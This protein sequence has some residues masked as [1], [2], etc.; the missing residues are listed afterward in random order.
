MSEIPKEKLDQSV[1]LFNIMDTDKDSCI[2]TDLV[3][4]MCKALG[5]IVDKDDHEKFMET[6]SDGKISYDQFL[7]FYKICYNKK[8]NKQAFLNAF[9]TLDETKS[10]SVSTKKLKHSLMTLG[11]GLSEKEATEALKKYDKNGKI[12]YKELVN[13]L[14]K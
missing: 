5:V 10:G 9:V 11:E 14:T 1:L 4:D 12:D 6:Y 13:E 7:D 2:S 3:L 8:I